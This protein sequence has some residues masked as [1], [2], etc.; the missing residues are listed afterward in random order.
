MSFSQAEHEKLENLILELLAKKPELLEPIILKAVGEEKLTRIVRKE[1]E[2]MKI[3]AMID[4][5]FD[6]FDKVFKALA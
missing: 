6:N 5:D 2:R 3:S 1:L 4:E